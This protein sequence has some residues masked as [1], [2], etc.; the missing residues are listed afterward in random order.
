MTDEQKM[1][2]CPV[3]ITEDVLQA[4]K[5][6]YDIALLADLAGNSALRAALQSALTAWN[7]RLPPEGGEAK[8]VGS[9]HFANGSRWRH[10]KTGHLYTTVGACR[11]EATNLPAYLYRG[12]ADGTVWARPMDEFLDGRFE[13]LSESARATGTGGDG[14]QP[15]ET[16][17]MDGTLI[18][19]CDDENEP[20][21]ARFDLRA[22]GFWFVGDCMEIDFEPTQ[23][24][25]LPSPATISTGSAK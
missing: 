12:D 7:K 6:G 5:R 18:L 14:W 19:V 2:P 10:V 8:L 3:E 25:A 20:T 21:T 17:P 11:I 16:A 13:R 9:D 1:M 23:W 4:F 24:R 22:G 15:I